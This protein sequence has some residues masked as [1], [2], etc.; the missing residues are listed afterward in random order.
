MAITIQQ[1]V[2]DLIVYAQKNL[3]VDKKDSLYYYNRVLSMIGAQGTTEKLKK[4]RISDTNP[5]NVMKP[6]LE[7]AKKNGSDNGDSEK[8]SA[9]ILS[10]LSLRPSEID[11]RFH[12]EG[13]RHGY[14]K[15]MNDLHAYGIAND[16]VKASAIARNIK[17]VSKD[18]LVITINLSKPEKD[19][20]QIAKLL[21]AVKTGYPACQLC[22]ENIGYCSGNTVRQTL[23][24]ANI[25]L[26]GQ[27][28]FWQ[29]SP[30]AYFYQH[31]IAVNYNHVPMNLTDRT[32][33]RLFDFVDQFPFYFLGSNAALP[34]VGGSILNH[35]HYQ[36]GKEVL[37]MQKAEARKSLGV[38][39]GVDVQILD[40][41]NSA[42][43]LQS[44]DRKAIEKLAWKLSCAWE[45]YDNAQLDIISHTDGERHNIFAPIARKHGDTY[46]LDIIF[47]NNRV[48]E[49]YP[50]GIFHAHKQYHNIKSEGIGLIEAMGLFVLPARLDRQLKEVEGYL[51]GEP[52]D[53]TSLASDMRIHGDMIDK[54]LADNGNSNTPEH[55]KAVVRAYVDDVCKNILYNTAVFKPD[56]QGQT[57]FEQ[58]LD[59]ALK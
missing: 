17:W 55:A 25:T 30:Y 35:D 34:R 27:K 41:Y 2:Y 39:D 44:A 43:R 59:S 7:F 56:E 23:R 15:A 37:P 8:F 14:E 24:W 5:D 42:V 31:G 29:F 19:N 36:G 12:A 28:W 26:D 3:G 40:W 20:K 58:F 52:Y 54:L 1:K 11:R 6:L 57:A 33:P 51:C 48:S 4:R 9:D 16:Y 18:G 53:R 47:R 32:V 21:T 22:A 49:E 38:T 46:I 10:L 13:R 45:N 50:D